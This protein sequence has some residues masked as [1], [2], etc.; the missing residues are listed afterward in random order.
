M[1][2]EKKEQA[3]GA[4]EKASGLGQE[5]QLHKIHRHKSILKKGIKGKMEKL[6]RFS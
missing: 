6:R 1:E 2:T 5:K 4:L 3:R